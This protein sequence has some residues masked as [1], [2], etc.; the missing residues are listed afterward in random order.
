MNYGT[1]LKGITILQEAR[2]PGASEFS[3]EERKTWYQALATLDDK[4]YEKAISRAVQECEFFPTIA[5]L[6]KLAEGDRKNKALEAWNDLKMRI[7]KVGYYGSPQFP[8]PVTSHVVRV[9]GGWMEVCDWYLDDY[10]W[11]KKEFVEQYELLRE[12]VVKEVP[13]IGFVEKTNRKKG[14]I[15]GQVGNLP[16]KV[17]R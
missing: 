14:F 8:D 1:F 15:Q 4:S 3:D 6:R 13:A 12:K 11:K 9:M 7:Q 5:K 2:F 10:P 16:V 17:G